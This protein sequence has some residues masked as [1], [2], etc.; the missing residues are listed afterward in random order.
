M[1]VYNGQISQ[2]VTVTFRL[3]HRLGPWPRQAQLQKVPFDF[4]RAARLVV[5]EQLIQASAPLSDHVTGVDNTVASISSTRK[6]VATTA[7]ATSAASPSPPARASPRPRRARSAA[8][9]RSTCLC[10]VLRCRRSVR[11]R[12]CR[13]APT[14]DNSSIQLPFL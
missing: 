13:H 11:F 14:T 1:L 7:S 3:V 10:S 4:L 2:L 6:Y 12:T 9:W 5:Q 8:S